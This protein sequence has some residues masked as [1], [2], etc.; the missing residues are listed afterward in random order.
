MLCNEIYMPQV[1]L[2]LKGDYLS[3]Q[4]GLITICSSKRE[5]DQETRWLGEVQG[6]FFQQQVTK[7]L[8]GDLG[9]ITMAHENQKFLVR[10]T[11]EECVKQKIFLMG[12]F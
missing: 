4:L 7:E 11:H 1:I 10:Q 12:L 2:A 8:L 6:I 3:V 5:K 9:K